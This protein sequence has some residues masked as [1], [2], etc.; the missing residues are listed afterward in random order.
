MYKEGICEIC[1]EINRN[2]VLAWGIYRYVSQKRKVKKSTS[3]S[4][5]EQVWQTGNNR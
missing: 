5:D 4:P 3:I 2:F 1:Q